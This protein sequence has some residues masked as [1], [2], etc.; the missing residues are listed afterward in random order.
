MTQQKSL[1]VKRKYDDFRLDRFLKEASFSEKETLLKRSEIQA[2][3]QAGKITMNGKKVRPSYRVRVGEIILFSFPRR[4]APLKETLPK[5]PVLFEDTNLLALSKPAGLSMHPRQTGEKGTLIDWLLAYSPAIAS[6]GE[7]P[8]RPGLVHRLDRETSGVV[9]VA[10]TKEAFLALKKLFQKRKIKKTYLALIYGELKEKKGLFE[11]SLGRI[12]GSLRRGSPLPTSKREFGGKTREALTEYTLHTSY[13]HYSFLTL[14]PKTGRTHQIRVHLSEKGHPIVGDELYRF[15]KHRKDPLQPPHQLLH[16]AK[17][18]F[19]LL[20]QNYSFEAPLPDY[21]R[22]TLAF[23]D[24]K[25]VN[26]YD[27]KA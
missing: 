24:G 18:S 22:E 8:L 2:L 26:R 10:K 19:S 9:V 13:P 11:A 21:F 12:R 14:E 27:G 25:G 1:T 5:I 23:L 17:L 15:K 16:A 6:I 20:G 4:K 7:D 3:I